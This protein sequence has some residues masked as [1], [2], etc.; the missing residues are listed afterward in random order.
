[1]RTSRILILAAAVAALAGARAA[2]DYV[3]ESR[4]VP[5]ASPDFDTVIES[6]ASGSNSAVTV[7]KPWLHTVMGTNGVMCVY[8]Q[9]CFT[10]TQDRRE[11]RYYRLGDLVAVRASTNRILYA[12]RFTASSVATNRGFVVV[13]YSN[14]L[15]RTAT[16]R[17]FARSRE[18]LLTPTDPGEKVAGQLSIEGKKAAAEKL[19]KAKNAKSAE[20][21]RS[22]AIRESLRM[23]AVEARQFKNGNT[24]VKSGAIVSSAA[25]KISVKGGTAT[26]K[27]ADGTERKL[28][29]RR[30]RSGGLK[31]VPPWD[32]SVVGKE[33]NLVET[34]TIPAKKE[35]EP[36]AGGGAKAKGD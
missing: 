23:Q 21:K 35:K 27:Y 19:E 28:T 11:E 29:V 20:Q 26:V 4:R 36:S 3:V 14:D 30:V 34:A 2:T 25:S 31:T 18:D 33:T 8:D 7:S 1:M 9:V 17:S 16:Q 10:D 13:S 6:W 12:T 32:E 22:D 15:T 24:Y 5:T